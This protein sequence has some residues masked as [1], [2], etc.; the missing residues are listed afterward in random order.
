MG[1]EINAATDSS[2]P[3]AQRSSSAASSTPSGCGTLTEAV[4]DETIDG[5]TMPIIFAVR[6]KVTGGKV[7]EIEQ[8]ITRKG[9]TM[10]FYDPQALL[11][12]RTRIG[13]ASCRRHSAALR[14][15]MNEQA[16]SI[17]AASPPIRRTC[18]LRLDLPPL[19]G[20]VH[21][22]ARNGNCS[23]KGPGAHAHASPVPVTDVEAGITAG[24]INFNQSLP[25]VH[26]FKF[27]DGKVVWIQ[28]CSADARKTP[29]GPTRSR[30][31]D[32]PWV[33]VA[34]GAQPRTSGSR[35]RRIARLEEALHE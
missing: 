22:T 24:F 16:N 25:D 5:V 6:L 27:R 1:V 9:A 30:P 18:Q 13:R 29:S 8:I 10:N 19:G 17:S 4:V 23:P 28:P 35:W 3:A 7:S 11:G 32:D 15:Y 26:M 31:T 12:R 14:A 34:S 21:T 33:G 2:R 20:G